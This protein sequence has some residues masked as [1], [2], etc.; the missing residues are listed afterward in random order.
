MEKHFTQEER[1]LL[2]LI[3]FFKK[4]IE[5]LKSENQLPQEYEQLAETCDKMAGQ[6]TIHA[7][8]REIV[9]TEREQLKKMI[10]DNAR[11]PKCLKP[12]FLKLIGTD[13]NDKGWKSN[14]YKCRKCNIEFV[15]NAPNN[16]WDMIP[17]AEKV[18]EDMEK[19]LE[20]ENPPEEVKQQTVAT[21]EQMKANL[22]RLKPVVE[23]ADKDFSDLEFREKEMSE[24]V[25]KFKKHLMIER[26]RISD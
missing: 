16:P 22:A 18:V 23:A 9:E 11:C 21:L 4:R 26:I 3:E 7:K 12:D 14:K 25:H 20:Q 17:Y 8:N 13:V 19:R 6:L 15:W 24:I 2:K 1:Q 5:K 10:K